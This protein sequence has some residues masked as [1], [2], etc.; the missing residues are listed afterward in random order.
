LVPLSESPTRM[1]L[2]DELD[3]LAGLH[4]DGQL[5]DPEFAAAKTRLLGAEAPPPAAPVGAAPVAGGIT[6]GNKVYRS[7]RWSAG[8]LFFPDQLTLADDGMHFRKGALFGSQEEHISYRAVASLRI[9][10][11]IFLSNLN[12]ETTGGSQPIFINGLWK[13]AAGEIQAAVQSAL[14]AR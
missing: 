13:A 14:S 7:S 2:T 11:G 12:V 5:T 4:R 9:R 6:T 8:N 10:N 1:N 3:Q